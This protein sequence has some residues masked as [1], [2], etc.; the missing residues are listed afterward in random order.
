MIRKPRTADSLP[1]Y[2]CGV[3]PGRAHHHTCQSPAAKGLRQ[4]KMRWA[5]EDAA[6]IA[7]ELCP[8]RCPA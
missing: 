3:L 2:D 5:E 8:A 1:C 7:D 4:A 6:G